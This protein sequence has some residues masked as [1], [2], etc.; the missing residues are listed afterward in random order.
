MIVLIFKIWYSILNV[1]PTKEIDL[2]DFIDAE[3]LFD[4]KKSRKKKDLK[5]QKDIK[6]N[7]NQN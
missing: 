7:L 5:M 4:R 3:I 6:W 1:P 2:N